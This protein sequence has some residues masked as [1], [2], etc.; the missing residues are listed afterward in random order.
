MHPSD[1]ESSDPDLSDAFD[2]SSDAIRVA[3]QVAH[4]FNNLL[5]SVI[6]HAALV[7][8]DVASAGLPCLEQI[9]DAAKRAAALSRQL[10]AFAGG[11]G[12]PPRQRTHAYQIV[13]DMEPLLRAIVRGRQRLE[14]APDPNTPAVEIDPV[15]LR[16]LVVQLVLA[17]VSAAGPVD[18]TVRLSTVA[19]EI[20]PDDISRYVGSVAI[21]PGLFV[22]LD[23]VYTRH[24][25]TDL[26]HSLDRLLTPRGVPM[27]SAIGGALCVASQEDGERA[28]CLL[29]Q[30][31]ALHT[32]E[33]W[34][35]E[36]SRRPGR[37]VLVADDERLVREMARSMLES[38]GL[39]V[40]TAVDGHD[41]LDAYRRHG[42]AVEAVLL[43]VRMP[44]MD[45]AQACQALLELNPDLGVVLCSGYAIDP[46]CAH[47]IER[48]NVGF[49]LK[50]Y[51][52]EKLVDAIMD[53]L[54]V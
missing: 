28:R 10:Q 51:T 25:E 23:V 20:G 39:A 45:G 27:I 53:A 13:R 42:R 46:D 31:V 30:A 19:V 6:G 33:D 22:S 18:S 52:R 49:L 2:R 50:P 34:G 32:A 43:D 8:G 16:H 12:A 4:E 3:A 41:A 54:S 15:E 14:L 40:V 11:Q 7:R 24:G 47:L 9:E 26:A 48:E 21:E 29:P 38:E 1:D 37:L 36:G 17:A 5:T 35:A 44:N